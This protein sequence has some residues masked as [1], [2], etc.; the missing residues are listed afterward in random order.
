MTLLGVGLAVGWSVRK[1]RAQSPSPEC[2]C[3]SRTS[4]AIET[5]SRRGRPAAT[6]ANCGPR[7]HGL[8]AIL[9]V[10]LLQNE[11]RP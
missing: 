1:R 7:A 10:G 5:P 2:S 11:L 8:G 4:A 3:R 6:T 9:S